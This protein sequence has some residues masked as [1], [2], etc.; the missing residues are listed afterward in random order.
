MPITRVFRMPS[1]VL[2]IMNFH[3]SI[4]AVLDLAKL[5]GLVSSGARPSRMLILRSEDVEAA[6]VAHD[7]FRVPSAIG[8]QHIQ[9][10]PAHLPPKHRALLEGIINLSQLDIEAPGA[11]QDTLTLLDTARLFDS[12]ELRALRKH[13]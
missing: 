2:G 8:V 10:L 7:V 1:F 11:G 5:L 9:P 13:R 12:A 6:I 4:V 3:G